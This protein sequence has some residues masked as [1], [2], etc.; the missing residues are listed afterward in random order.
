MSNTLLIWHEFPEEVKLFKL[1]GWGKFAKL[2][3]K[4]AAIGNYANADGNKPSDPIEKLSSL[5]YLPDGGYAVPVL[6]HKAPILEHFD[7][8]IVCGAFL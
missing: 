4:A 2:A 8:I 1:N 3:R 5:L 7:E 6:S